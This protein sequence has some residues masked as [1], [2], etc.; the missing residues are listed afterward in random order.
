LSTIKKGSLYWQFDV[1]LH[2]QDENELLM[3]PLPLPFKSSMFEGSF[4][5]VKTYSIITRI[6][7]QQHLQ[8][9]FFLGYLGSTL[10]SSFDSTND[11][12]AQ[13]TKTSTVLQMLVSF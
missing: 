5:L 11:W 8:N 9:L 3:F 7:C 4:I 13:G 1:D 12:P 2:L 10:T 6:R